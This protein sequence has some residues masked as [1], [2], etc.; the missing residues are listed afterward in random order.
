MENKLLK[1]KVKEY[2]RKDAQ[3]YGSIF[4]KMNKLE[5]VKSTVSMPLL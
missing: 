4:A 2:N 1:E 5:Q 3:F